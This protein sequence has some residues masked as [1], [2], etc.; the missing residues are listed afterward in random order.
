MADS[1][2]YGGAFSL[3]SRTVPSDIAIEEMMKTPPRPEKE[4]LAEL[5]QQQ[6]DRLEW[7]VKDAAE[8]AQK[9]GSHGLSERNIRAY[10][11]SQRKRIS[12]PKIKAFA[13]LFGVNERD[14][15]GRFHFAEEV[16]LLFDRD[17][18]IEDQ[19]DLQEGDVV[20]VL[21][22]RPFLEAT[23]RD[24]RNVVLENLARG[25]TYTYYF[26]CLKRPY[27]FDNSAGSSYLLF[28]E[29]HVAAYRNFARPPRLFG[30]SVAPEKFRYFSD[31]QTIVRYQVSRQDAS[32]TYGY[33][34]LSRR[35]SAT[36]EKGWY[37]VPEDIW[38]KIDANLREARSPVADFDLPFLALNSR[39]RTVADDYSSWFR[40][41]DMAERYNRLRLALGHKS[42]ECVQRIAEE[43]NTARFNSKD[44]RYLD[45]GCGDG[46]IT[47]EV[48]RRLKRRGNVKVY[49]IDASERQIELARKTF[50][51]DAEFEFEAQPLSFEGPALDAAGFDLI[52]SIH[53]AYALDECYLRR[54]FELLAPGGLACIWLATRE[55][56]VIMQLSDAL[57]GLLRPGQTRNSAEDVIAYTRGAGL[58]PDYKIFSRNVPCPFLSDGGDVTEQGKEIAKF[59]ALLARDLNAKELN[60]AT[61]VLNK[62]RTEQ[63]HQ[64]IQD[65]LIIFLR[66]Q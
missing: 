43:L 47:A 28:R 8:E 1:A 33:I 55:S 56:N 11:S 29:K 59:C 52:T 7:S 35:G 62:T 21:S 64:P 27:P 32:A 10:L 66:R 19:N 18:I 5:I 42:D 44:L 57:D 36:S 49:G 30:F 23:D 17:A 46:A 9:V 63:G 24:F 61:E 26:P 54:I 48:A 58:E 60:L 4:I 13:K 2:H 12:R 50:L 37:S 6:L 25:V 51:D 14:W 41:S 16:P 65:G 45:I 22:T 38:R 39:I 40:S 3:Q 20:Y 31:L 15:L 34:E 53:S